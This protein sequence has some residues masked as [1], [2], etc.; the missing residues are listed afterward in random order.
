MT[1]KI[2]MLSPQSAELDTALRLVD[3]VTEEGSGTNFVPWFEFAEALAAYRTH[4]Y[5][6]VE[7]HLVSA[8]QSP[9]Q[10]FAAT[11]TLLRSL[12]HRQ[13]KRPQDANRL[14]HQAHQRYLD[15]MQS[16]AEDLKR[17]WQDRII[18][19]VLYKEAQRDTSSDQQSQ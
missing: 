11:A 17:D 3:V 13:L 18:F 6:R 4:H 15:A 12:T 5:D 19:E 10:F 2:C 7:E 14:L 9:A 8:E 1:A 16:P